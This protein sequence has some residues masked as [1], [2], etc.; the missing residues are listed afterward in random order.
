[1]L[2]AL[3]NE[4]TAAENA[5]GEA[6]FSSLGVSDSTARALSE[7][8]FAAP[9]IIQKLSI[10]LVME[11]KDLIGQSQT[12]SGKTAAFGVPAIEI[13]EPRRHAFVEVLVLCPTRELAMQAC[14]EMKKFARYKPGVKI[15]PIYGGQSI[16]R[17][18]KLLRSPTS[19]VIGTPGRVMDLMRRH[20]LKLDNVRLVVLDEAD[21]MLNMGFKEDIETILRGV[22]EERQTVLFSATMSPEIMKI[23]R[24]FL[25]NPEIVRAPRKQLTVSTIEQ[26]YFD[27][28]RGSSKLEVLCNAIDLYNPS[29]SIVFS[30]TK[31]QVDELVSEMQSR[32]F[33]IAG[34]HGD[35]KQGE[36][37]RV[38]NDFKNGKIGILVA[39]DVAARGIDV[40]DVEIVFNYDIPQDLEY[41]VHRIGRT[42]RAG[43][44]GKSFTLVAGRNQFIA[45]RDIE[46]FTG[47]RIERVDVPS[48]T[49]VQEIK[50]G[51]MLETIKKTLENEKL[52]DYEEIVNSL[53]EEGFEPASV[54]AAIMRLAY[55]DVVA[56]P[57]PQRL[58]S[59]FGRRG[60]MVKFKVGVG[61]INDITAGNI[62]GAIAAQTGLPGSD[63]GKI[64]LYDNYSLFEVP[65][66]WTESIMAKIKNCRIK[67]VRVTAELVG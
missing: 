49:D 47:K 35:M 14:D 13:C 36:R 63:V 50:R 26:Y 12:G 2:E 17:Q 60:D 10:P 23:T 37:T 51:R 16:D 59:R 33:F 31:K 7:I 32:G 45:L 40:E 20:S 22:P 15:V 8:G 52:A 1:M 34:L 28:P 21:E 58:G 29:R 61:R 57:E 43:K 46:R 62:L 54:A 67:G 53:T 27:I 30:N 65:I 18:I 4:E 11:G 64:K 56:Q 25:K 44:S 55:K 9:T 41:Y 42:G 39:T 3:E 48:A 24:Q 19:I 66:S 5:D 6:T 38:M